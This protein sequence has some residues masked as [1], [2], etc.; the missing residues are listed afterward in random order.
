MFLD[1]F[2]NKIGKS[3]CGSCS[4]QGKGYF[5]QLLGIKPRLLDLFE[6]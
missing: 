6:N 2:K 5:M 4:F 3:F 1:N